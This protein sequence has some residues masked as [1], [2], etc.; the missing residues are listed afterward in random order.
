[1]IRIG[2]LIP[3][4]PAQTHMFFWRE[5]QQLIKLGLVP[6]LISTRR[7]P[8]SLKSHVWCADAESQTEYLSSVTSRGLKSFIGGLIRL[9]P[10]GLLKCLKF[11]VSREWAIK[12]PIL[13]R[14]GL[15]L[16]AIRLIGFLRN[17]GISHLH[18]HSCADSAY[19]GLFSH[20]L[21]NISYSMTLHGPLSY[22]GMHQNEKWSNASFALTVTKKLLLEVKCSLGND[23]P[24]K[25]AAVSMGVDV[26][27]FLRSSPY[28]PWVIGSE[29]RLFSCGRLNPGKGHGDLIHAVHMLRLEGVDARL[30]IA[31]EDET[32]G[33]GYRLVLEKL[34]VDLGLDNSIVQFIGA[35]SEDQVI[36][37]LEQA[38]IFVLASLAEAIGVAI[39]EAM[40]MAVPVIATD[41]GGTDELICD[42]TH[43]ILLPPQN[44]IALVAAIKQIAFYPDLA[45][46]LS[47]SERLR[48]LEFTKK[49]D[50]AAVIAGF[51]KNSH[52]IS[53]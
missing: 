33:C 27:K 17:N 8:L 28:V 5:I 52:N 7:P 9:Q 22:Y 20:W 29:L 30:V 32:G 25:L 37:S 53:K 34:V 4:F 36:K 48:L 15:V 10:A 18:I 46:N 3:E 44:P 45:L 23:V 50:S 51:F 40:A 11:V 43:G 38:H 35:V 6:V 41:A 12:T 47:T 31:G 16:V 24:P 26:S 49:N 13:H 1:M 42:C 19:L 39:M 2:Y 14:I 21:N